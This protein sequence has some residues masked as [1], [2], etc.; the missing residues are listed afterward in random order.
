MRATIANEAASAFFAR[1]AIMWH[2]ECFFW[3]LQA[4]MVG[5]LPNDWLSHV[6]HAGS[7]GHLALDLL[8][9]QGIAPAVL[10]EHR[11]G[12]NEAEGNVVGNAF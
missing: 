4:E 8:F 12:F 2:I 7:K 9:G 6:I 11:P 5:Q 10:D 3:D 1:F